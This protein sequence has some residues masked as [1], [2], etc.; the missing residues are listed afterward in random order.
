MKNEAQH[1]LLTQ[2]ITGLAAATGLKPEDVAS[3]LGRP[4]KADMGDYAFPC[5]VYAK[6]NKLNPQ[7]AAQ[8]IADTLKANT[9]LAPFLADATTAGA[10]LNIRLKP[11]T[12]CVS[13][14]NAIRASQGNY[15]SG[16]DGA[17]KTVVID[18][19]APNIAKPF[20]VGHLMSTILGA[21]L[22]K[23]FRALGYKVV[24]VNHLGDWGV[25][26]GFQFLAWD[27]TDHATRDANLTQHGLDYLADLYVLINMP[28]RIAGNAADFVDLPFSDEPNKLKAA[29]GLL[30]VMADDVATACADIP[31]TFPRIPNSPMVGPWNAFLTT[32]DAAL[33]EIDALSQSLSAESATKDDVAKSCARFGQQPFIAV[34]KDFGAAFDLQAR[35]LFKKL[36]DGDA[37]L[38]ALWE[39]LRTATLKQLQKSY[40]RLGVSFDSD[41]GEG[42]YEPM[43]KPLLEDLKTRGIAVE[44]EGALVIPMEDAPPKTEKD[45]KPPFILLKA[46]KATIYGTRDLAAALYRKKTYDFDKNL[47]VVDVR[48]S[49]HFRD[50][51][52]SIGKIG[53]AWN[54]D[55]AH[56][57]FG[58]MSIKAGDQILAMSTRG[59]RMVPLG[60]L[61][62]KMVDVVKNIVKEKNPDIGPDKIDS[63]A[64][65][66][67][68]GAIIFWIQA[69]RRAS[70]FVFDWQQATDAQGDT[71]PYLQYTHARTC[72][73]LR[74]AGVAREDWLTA[75]LGLLVEPE[76]VAVIRALEAFPKVL[77]Q[78]AKDYE[79]S[80]LATWALELSG[81][82]SLFLNRHRV[83]D[84][85]PDLKRARVALVDTVREV[86]ARALALMGV[87]APEEM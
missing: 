60:Q 33:V 5:F 68:V 41:A 44:S 83:I 73:I 63:V 31:T 69:R 80:L 12:L 14:I 3:Q 53:H 9:A 23:I 22:V 15:G 48:Q 61:L 27:L 17:G 25:Q 36:E 59:G 10:F 47:Y 75:D 26:C 77:R 24:G 45:K 29:R 70:N 39:K 55:C 38:K 57:A 78:A 35:E 1:E 72:G 37:G 2:L 50:L 20:H 16:T 67:G 51:F 40:D 62:D 85:A 84:S 56:V 19:S 65:A 86:L 52:K 58:L 42:F 28:G 6:A 54:K 82:F 81:A 49:D 30:K 32:K 13:V 43:L 79:P 76:E 4:P 8:Q 46:D 18:Y 71:G 21:S 66:V 64:E 74:K 11:G 87:K 7:A 34:W